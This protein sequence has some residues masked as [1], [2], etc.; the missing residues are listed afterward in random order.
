MRPGLPRYEIAH[1]EYWS[2]S[3]VT[4][5]KR[6]DIIPMQMEI[7]RICF[8]HWFH[9]FVCY[10]ARL[11]GDAFSLNEKENRRVSS[12]LGFPVTLTK[13]PHREAQL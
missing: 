9:L 4:S 10:C 5:D 6:V 2:R 7:P 11:L 12:F 8:Q 1:C 13:L 3:A